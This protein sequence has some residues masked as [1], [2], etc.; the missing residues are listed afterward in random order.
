MA[1]KVYNLVT[2]YYNEKWREDVGLYSVSG[3]SLFFAIQQLK[4][5]LAAKWKIYK[6]ST[7]IEQIERVSMTSEW[8]DAKKLRFTELF[9]IWLERGTNISINQAILFVYKNMF[10]PL[11]YLMYMKLNKWEK[12]SDIFLEYPN[13]FNWFYCNI[14]KWY[15]DKSGDQSE[16][17]DELIKFYKKKLELRS[18]ILSSSVTSLLSIWVAVISAFVLD[19]ASYPN[20]KVQYMWYPLPASVEWIHST[21]T[22]FKENLFLLILWSMFL[23]K[24]LKVLPLDWYKVWWGKMMLQV[25]IL[26]QIKKIEAESLFINM[27]VAMDKA[28]L[29]PTQI[30][31]IIADS[32]D[33]AYIKW[34]IKSIKDDSYNTWEELGN[35]MDNK[36]RFFSE[37][38][39]ITFKSDDIK[40]ELLKLRESYAKISEKNLDKAVKFMST[41]LMF[42]SLVFGWYI[43]VSFMMGTMGIND[44][45]MKASKSGM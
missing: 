36:Y 11:I 16:W 22:F 3:S 38:I 26:W 17:L 5:D 6:Q 21:I 12:L 24:L 18:K 20:L 42:A 45:I 8:S 9:K 4:K 28:H 30:L 33:N 39:I 31:S 10:D 37:D 13:V 23:S 2:L 7:E 1:N 44:I 27:Y 41:I 25:P 19:V 34:I 15:F 40:K 32:M 35:L 14:I 43:V 29:T